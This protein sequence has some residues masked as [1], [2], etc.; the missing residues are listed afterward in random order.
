LIYFIANP[1]EVGRAFSEF[2]RLFGYEE[3][4]QLRG[5]TTVRREKEAFYDRY[6]DLY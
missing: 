4:Y 6:D 5:L 2:C 3:T 1:V